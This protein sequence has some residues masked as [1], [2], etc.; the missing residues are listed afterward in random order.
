M[1]SMTPIRSVT[2]EVPDASDVVLLHRSQGGLPDRPE[3]GIDQSGSAD[4]SRPEQ[5]PPLVSV[6]AV[7]RSGRERTHLRD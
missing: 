3:P 6:G 4:P 1:A 5:S 7:G 2:R